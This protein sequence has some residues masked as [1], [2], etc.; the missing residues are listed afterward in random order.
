MQ[1][2]QTNGCNVPTLILLCGY[3]FRREITIDEIINWLVQSSWKV[4]V[5]NEAMLQGEE[6]A[7]RQMSLLRCQRFLAIWGLGRSDWIMRGHKKAN[8][9]I[10]AEERLKSQLALNP[11]SVRLLSLCAEKW[12]QR[13]QTRVNVFLRLLL[14]RPLFILTPWALCVRR[15]FA[16]LQI[17]ESMAPTH[18]SSSGI[19]QTG[20]G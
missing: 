5:N 16:R 15:Q 2:E 8:L 17:N 10:W 20:R 7:G 3:Y 6:L 19:S 4:N 9:D 12:R 14:F 13:Q 1:Y 18:W 11:G